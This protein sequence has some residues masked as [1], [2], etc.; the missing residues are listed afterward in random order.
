M[1]HEPSAVTATVRCVFIIDPKRNVRA[2]IYYPLNV[3]RNFDEITRVVDA[4]QTVD[5][6]AVACPANWKP[7]DEVIVPPP[8]TVQA[9][10]ERVANKQLN[11]TDWYFSKKKL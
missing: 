6:N 3:G 2:M 1:I 11:V 5:A 4:L 8:T 7:G 10:D 9:A